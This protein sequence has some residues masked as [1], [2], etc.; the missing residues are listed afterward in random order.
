MYVF[1]D[2]E[3]LVSELKKA[4]DEFVKEAFMKDICLLLAVNDITPVL[5]QTPCQVEF[6]QENGTMYA[7][8]TQ[9]IGFTELDTTEHDA[10]VAIAAIDALVDK[11]C[12]YDFMP[13]DFIRDVAK[14]VKVG[15]NYTKP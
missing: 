11:L 14:K 7:T 2:F 9:R 10:K 4:E 1:E 15:F 3:N 12:E 8:A 6:S 13:N 5:T